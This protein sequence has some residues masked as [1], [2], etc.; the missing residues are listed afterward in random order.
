MIGTNDS[1]NFWVVLDIGTTE[2]KAALVS[3][4][5][6]I[7]EKCSRGIQTDKPSSGF[8]EQDADK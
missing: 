6:E 3:S 2:L 5:G 8:D 4:K 1:S 7:Q